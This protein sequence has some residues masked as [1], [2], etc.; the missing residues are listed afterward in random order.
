MS[1]S[2]RMAAARAL[3]STMP[4]VNRTVGRAM[5]MKCSSETPLLP[6]QYRL[7]GAIGRRARTLGEVAR[8][9]GVTP[10]TATTLVTTLESRGW[11]NREHD[12][13]DRRRVVVSLTE[14]GATVLK[15]S[16][17]VAEGAMADLLQPLN[18]EQLARLLDGLSVL[19]ELGKSDTAR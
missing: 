16:Q 8:I 18:A 13:D 17:I 12:P 4:L 14:G 9:Q 6:Q 5:R 1:D 7:L 11:V 15:R 2:K 10:A 3:L 19:G